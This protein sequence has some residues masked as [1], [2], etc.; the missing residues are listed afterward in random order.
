MKLIRDSVTLFVDKITVIEPEGYVRDVYGFANENGEVVIPH[1][2]DRICEVLGELAIVVIEN[3]EKSY[4]VINAQGTMLYEYDDLQ[5]HHDFNRGAVCLDG[6]WGVVNELFE[7]ICPIK[8]EDIAWYNENT[9]FVRLNDKWGAVNFHNELICDFMFDDLVQPPF[10]CERVNIFEGFR[11]ESNQLIGICI[12]DKWGF[13]TEDFN[14]IC[15]PKYDSISKFANGCAAVGIGDR[16][17]FIDE[18]A[19]EIYP[20]K[21]TTQ[22]AWKIDEVIPLQDGEK[23]GWFDSQSK[24]LCEP[25]YDEEVKIINDYIIVTLSGKKGIMRRNGVEVCPLRNDDIEPW[26]TFGYP[27]FVA[28]LIRI[29][30]KYG[31]FDPETGDYILEPIYDNVSNDGYDRLVETLRIGTKYGYVCVKN[32]KVVKSAIIYDEIKNE[33]NYLIVLRIGGKWGAHSIDDDNNVVEVLECKYD[34]I[35]SGY[36]YLALGLNG[37]Y[38]YAQISSKDGLV[39]MICDYKYDYICLDVDLAAVRSGEK[40]GVINA[41]GKEICEIKY[42]DIRH[43]AQPQPFYDQSDIEYPRLFGVMLGD[44]WGFINVQGE[45]ICPFQFDRIER[46]TSEYEGDEYAAY[47][48]EVCY[49]LDKNST[50][51]VCS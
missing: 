49:M 34:D 19:N 42:D 8:Y 16:V 50:F 17:G 6:K 3:D 24:Y 9:I 26:F 46:W 27:M 40:W 45:E 29:E 1:K 21:Y 4:K 18:N 10:C 22:S 37:K 11:I 23:Y 48:G 25:K 33:W 28:F 31:V 41:D 32:H 5:W 38:A 43:S 20:V 36:G 14:V 44:K 47:I 2:Y 12:N 13:M 15:E 35:N 30:G 51:V 39:R 7:V